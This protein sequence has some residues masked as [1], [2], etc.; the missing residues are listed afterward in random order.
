MAARKQSGKVKP[1]CMTKG[2]QKLT[3]ARGVCQSCLRDLNELVASG[4][5]TDEEL[6]ARKAWA[7]RGRP[8]RKRLGK[9]A[10]ALG[11]V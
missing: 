1:V 6:V 4:K 8:G 7:P 9:A 3:H 11:L 2:C 5:F 10:K